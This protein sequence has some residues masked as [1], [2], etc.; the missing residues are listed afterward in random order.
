MESDDQTSYP[1][2]EQPRRSAAPWVI[3]IILLV[4]LCC[5]CVIVGSGYY[6]GDYLLEFLEEF[7]GVNIY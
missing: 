2:P 6:F 5:C 3:L 4:L 1:T 7:L